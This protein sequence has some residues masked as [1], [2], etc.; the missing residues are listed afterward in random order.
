MIR[1]MAMGD[2]VQRVGD[3]IVFWRNGQKDAG[4]V[5]S[6]DTSKEEVTFNLI[7]G[8]DKGRE[9]TANYDPLQVVNVYDEDSAIAA[10]LEK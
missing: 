7:S 9:K 6:C 2:A 1:K 4:K 3:Y 8:P 5:L 10:V